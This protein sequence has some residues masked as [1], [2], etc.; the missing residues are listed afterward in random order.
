MAANESAAIASLRTLNT[1][2]IA[3][4]SAH[5]EAGYTCSLSDLSSLNDSKL[6]SGQKN[7]YR[8]ELSGCAPADQGPANTKY[9]LVAYPSVRNQTGVR[10]FC[11]DE[12]GVIG[13][14]ME[15]SGQG[16]LESGSP[17]N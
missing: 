7:G 13:V 14:D 1:A 12:S 9:Q 15:G 3:Y 5:S 2:E 11:S 16:C 4:S 8:F 6:A 10:A 17:L